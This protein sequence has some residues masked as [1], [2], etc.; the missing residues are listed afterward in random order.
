MKAIWMKLRVALSGR[1]IQDYL[2]DRL[3]PDNHIGRMALAVAAECG[4]KK[5]RG[6]TYG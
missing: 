2:G 6:H 1:S 5:E 3:S 4:N